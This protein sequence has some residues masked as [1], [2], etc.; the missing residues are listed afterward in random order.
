[1]SLLASIPHLFKKLF[2]HKTQNPY[3]QFI[4]Y[5]FVSGVAL[6][7]DFGGMVLL[8]EAFHVNYLVAATLSFTAGLV[9]N[10]LLSLIWV[11]EKSKHS[12]YVE[13][14][15]FSGIGIAGLVINDLVIWS[16]TDKFGVYYMISKLVATVMTFLW[17]FSIRKFLLFSNRE[18]M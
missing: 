7:V 4:R 13:F 12:R 10:Y 15:I 8:K 5:G 2:V 3:I 18:K 9:V 14:A 16:L 17:N 11:F 6:V 1:M